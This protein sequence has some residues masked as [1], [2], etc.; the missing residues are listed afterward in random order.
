MSS[1]VQKD[2]RVRSLQARVLRRRFLSRAAVLV[3][4]FTVVYTAAMWLCNEYVVPRIANFVADSTSSWQHMSYD[5]FVSYQDSIIEE[6]GP[7]AMENIQVTVPPQDFDVRFDVDST[8]DSSSES[9]SDSDSDGESSESTSDT[10]TVSSDSDESQIVLAVRDLTV[11]NT[12][13]AFK[14]PIAVIGYFGGLLIIVSLT[15][16][17]ILRLIDELSASVTQLFRDKEQPIVLPGDLA[18]V[19]HELDTIRLNALV[20]ERAARAA[21]C[22]KNELVAYLAHD[23]RTPLTAVI[24]YV[25]LLKESPDL[26]RETRVSYADVALQ[27]AEHLK[28]LVDEFFEITRYSLQSISIERQPVDLA[29]FCDQ[30]ID[31]FMPVAQMREIELESTAPD[32]I[33]VFID[34]N[35]LARVLC[36]IVRNA[37]VYADTHTTVRLVARVEQ[38]QLIFTV[39][40]EGQEISAEHLE[41]IFDQFFREQTPRQDTGGAGLGLAIAR[42]IMN[43]HGGSVEASSVDGVTSFTVTLPF[44]TQEQDLQA[45]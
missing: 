6:H 1:S 25:S 24:G 13:R 27:K 3:V 8:A 22:R 33:E 40:N 16:N 44:R 19:N 18:I 23:I 32:N 34:P 37:L 11:Y 7:A 38:G 5:E 29:L 4:L 20:D 2:T 28:R 14:I 26:P 15:L 36:N 10:E 45:Q 31:E 35:K 17:R 43:A 12:L 30:I 41:R 39:S 21:E 9:V 42:E